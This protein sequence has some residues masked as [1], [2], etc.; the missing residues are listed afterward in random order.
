MDKN[1][2]TNTKEFLVTIKKEANK[3]N[4]LAVRMR[5]V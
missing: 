5:K 1:N 2:N 3:T 4:I